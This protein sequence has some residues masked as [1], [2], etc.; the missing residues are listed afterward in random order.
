M[1]VQMIGKCDS[2]GSEAAKLTS[3][4]IVNGTFYGGLKVAAQNLCFKCK[5][6]EFFYLDDSNTVKYNNVT[7]EVKSSIDGANSG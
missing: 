2:C 7:T 4:R 3:I 1:G 6:A 5:A